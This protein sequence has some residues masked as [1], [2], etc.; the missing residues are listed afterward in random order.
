MAIKPDNDSE[1]TSNPKRALDIIEYKRRHGQPID[2]WFFRMNPYA[3]SKGL[4]LGLA[5]DREKAEIRK[6][7]GGKNMEKNIKE[8]Y[9]S[10]SALTPNVK[11][12]A[13]SGKSDSILKKQG[14]KQ[15][16]KQ[17]GMKRTGGK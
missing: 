1:V 14:P 15:T 11:T 10:G 4:T 12:I 16:E 7:G 3:A 5:M 2:P 8:K 13:N 9:R 6:M 17:D